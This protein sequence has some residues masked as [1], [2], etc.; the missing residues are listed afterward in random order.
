MKNRILL[1]LL[2]VVLVGALVG[3]GA[4]RAPAP[5]EEK[6]PP[7]KIG[8][9]RGYT[10][11]VALAGPATAQGVEYI[12]NEAGWEIG[13]RTLIL[14][15]ED[16][17][18]TPDF[19]VAKARKLVEQDK[20]D[21][22]LGPLIADSVVAVEA[23]CKLKGVLNLPEGPSDKPVSEHAFFT[24]YGYTVASSYP[25]GLWCYDQ[26][27]ARE[28]AFIYTDYLYSQQ[29]RDGFKAAF[30]ERGGTILSDSGTQWGTVDFAP[31][32]QAVPKGA[33]VLVVFFPIDVFVPFVKQCAEFGLKMPIFF[34]SGDVLDEGVLAAAGD[35]SLGVLGAGDY[36]PEIDTPENKNFVNKWKADYEYTPG[37][38]S[39][40][41]YRLMRTYLEALKSTGGDPDPVKVTQALLQIKPF[42]TPA[43]PMSF[44]PGRICIHNM[45]IMKVVMKD[46][47]CADVVQVY[48]AVQPK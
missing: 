25:S 36:T 26:L 19:A 23:Y 4:C 40:N 33:D 43:G 34:M 15:Q 20:V 29:L 13:G 41:G 37:V 32:I 11:A 17:S 12:L 42:T 8:L 16:S 38:L 10:G 44:S 35:A 28:V 30:T 1:V 22:V 39:L 45:Y 3:F 7:I 24:N 46:R 2:A 18:D 47:L 5:T 48:P 6:L 31:Y 21:V 27:G 14:L 9:L